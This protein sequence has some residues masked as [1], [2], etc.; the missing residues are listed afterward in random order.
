MVWNNFK[1]VIPLD[2]KE[3][4]KRIHC[5]IRIVIMGFKNATLVFKAF[6]RLR[7]VN[8]CT[9]ET[10]NVFQQGGSTPNG[11]GIVMSTLTDCYAL[12]VTF[13]NQSEIGQVNSL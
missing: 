3:K 5:K 9:E 1:E 11:G 4:A 10:T 7:E 13:V 6:E 12:G 8:I 2:S